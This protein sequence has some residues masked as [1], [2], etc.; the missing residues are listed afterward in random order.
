MCCAALGGVFKLVEICGNPRIKL[1]ENKSK[2]RAPA[3]VGACEA[4]CAPRPLM[5]ESA[6]AV[7]PILLAKLENSCLWMPL[8][9][10]CD[11]QNKSKVRR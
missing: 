10:P 11:E 5:R 3:A 9:R 8:L 2:V 7:A 6:M 4:H 1:S